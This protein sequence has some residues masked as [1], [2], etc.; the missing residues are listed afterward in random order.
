M[1]I[2][3]ETQVIPEKIIEFPIYHSLDDE[4][5]TN[6]IECLE[7][8]AEI[9]FKQLKRISSIPSNMYNIKVDGWYF[10]DI[11]Y[12]KNNDDIKILTNFIEYICKNY[13]KDYT[14]EMKYNEGYYALVY[15][16]IYDVDD[17][18]EE[19]PIDDYTLIPIKEYL[20]K[21]NDALIDWY[22]KFYNEML[23]D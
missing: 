7:H 5:F 3:Y 16:R 22:N 17:Q 2:T 10:A 9:E 15:S 4:I 14:W 11:I 19:E 23:D 1:K 6:E 20:E 21:I 13:F 8:D 12:I 18:D